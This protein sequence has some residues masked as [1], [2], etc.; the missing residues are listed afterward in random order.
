MTSKKLSRTFYRE[1]RNLLKK[2]HSPR[3]SVARSG[4]TS[5][6]DA[7]EGVFVVSRRTIEPDIPMCLY[8]GIF[9]PGL[10]PIAIADDSIVYLGNEMPPSGVN[11]DENAYILN[12]S[13]LG[14]YLD[15]LALLASEPPTISAANSEVEPTLTRRLDVNP[16]ACGH[17][18]NHSSRRAN[19]MFVPFFWKDV[20]PK[21]ATQRQDPQ[22][23]DEWLASLPNTMRNDNSPWYFDGHTNELCHFRANDIGPQLLC[24]AA[25]CSLRTMEPGEEAFL[26]YGLKLPYPPWAREW[27]G[28]AR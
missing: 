22:H 12:L 18:V 8:P 27:Y 25:L 23:E 19:V 9:T 7:G 4:I 24:G 6:A 13:E 3:V 26:D 28:G 11:N 10:P 14:G 1:I 20:F 2:H 21:D 17:K 5:N 16:S 15:G